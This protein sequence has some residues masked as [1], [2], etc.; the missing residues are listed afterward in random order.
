M[1][2]NLIKQSLIP[3]FLSLV[4]LVV[5]GMHCATDGTPIVDVRQGFDHE[6]L[7]IVP[8]GNFLADWQVAHPGWSAWIAGILMLFAG[9]TLGRLTVRYNLYGTG[10]CIAIPLYGMVMCSALCERY[11]LTTVVASLFTTL[12]VKNLCMSYR[13]GFGFDRI[14]RGAMFLALLLLLEPTTLPL[15]VA[16][17][18]ATS[19]FRR[20]IREGV[21]AVAGFLFPVAT[22]CYLNWA[23]GGS[24]TAPME[25]LYRIFMEGEWLQAPLNAPQTQQLFV[26][27]L[28][29]LTIIA[30]VLFQA[31]S[32][33]INTK[34]RHILR[35]ACRLVWCTLLLFLL[36]HASTRLLGVLAVP[37]SL[38]LPVLFIRTHQSIAQTLYL[39][40]LATSI[41]LMFLH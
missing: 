36:P 26:G 33:A 24:F 31:N 11:Y 32:Y 23:I 28:L 38:L 17:P 3:A 12:A 34:A 8:L 13:N 6:L 1:R 15:V 25:A 21:I 5:L 20:T 37:T 14:F 41:G 18:L 19:L 16:L 40:L 4:L 10:T 39:L 22:L 30:M 27:S 7:P 9:T 29:L 35:F 2:L